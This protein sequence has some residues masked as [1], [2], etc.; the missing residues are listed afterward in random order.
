MSQEQLDYIVNNSEWSEEK[1][2]WNANLQ[3]LKDIQDEH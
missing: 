1:R 2:E 3:E